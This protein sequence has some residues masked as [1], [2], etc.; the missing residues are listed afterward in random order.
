MSP[1]QDS[2]IPEPDSMTVDPANLGSVDPLSVEGIFLVALSKSGTE[3]VA[4]LSVQC[5]DSSQRQ[6]LLRDSHPGGGERKICHD[7]RQTGDTRTRRTGRMANNGDSGN[8]R[9]L[10]CL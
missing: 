4:F 3:R 9:N 7:L 2:E 1:S 8:T 5:V 10:C 6:C